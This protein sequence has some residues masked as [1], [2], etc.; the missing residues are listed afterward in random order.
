M[1]GDSGNGGVVQGQGHDACCHDVLHLRNNGIPD[2]I[3]QPRGRCA[4]MQEVSAG[5]QFLM[6]C[7]RS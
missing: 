2:A 4:R 5:S 7:I 6:M 1:C 3:H